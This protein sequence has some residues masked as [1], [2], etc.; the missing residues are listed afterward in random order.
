MTVIVIFLV[1][2]GIIGVLWIGANDVRMGV[3]TPGRAGAV[4]DSMR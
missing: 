2:A 1:F 3:M 4:R